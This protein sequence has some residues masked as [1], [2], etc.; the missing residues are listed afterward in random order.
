MLQAHRVNVPATAWYLI[1]AR[2]FV[3]LF[4]LQSVPRAW[5]KTVPDK[6]STAASLPPLAHDRLVLPAS[7]GRAG[8]DSLR[9]G[10]QWRS[11]DGARP[12]GRT[13][14]STARSAG[15]VGLSRMV[16]NLKTHRISQ[17]EEARA[18]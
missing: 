18:D 15:S 16:W 11:T 9:R 7:C 5:C 17:E 3:L 12:S 8:D 6:R 10:E 14:H 1:Q 13:Y 4:R 2:L